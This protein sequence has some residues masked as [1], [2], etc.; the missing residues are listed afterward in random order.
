MVTE[1]VSG[2]EKG[3]GWEDTWD[4]KEERLSEVADIQTPKHSEQGH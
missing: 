3:W 4:M 2:D 1:R